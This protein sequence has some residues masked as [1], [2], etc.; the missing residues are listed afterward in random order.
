[1]DF[2]EWVEIGVKN[3]WVG[4]PHCDT[5]DPDLTEEEIEDFDEGNDPCRVC[6]RVWYV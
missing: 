3:K 4:Y 1:M 2:I 5:H 6:M